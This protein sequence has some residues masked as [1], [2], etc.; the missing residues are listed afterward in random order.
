MDR[1]NRIRGAG[2]WPT[3][4]RGCGAGTSL[5]SPVG[6]RSACSTNG[7]TRVG[8]A[9]RRPDAIPDCR[10]MQSRVTG[11]ANSSS[12]PSGEW[13]TREE[14]VAGCRS[15]SAATSGRSVVSS[16]RV[17]RCWQCQD[18][19]R[20]LAHTPPGQARSPI[21]AAARLQTRNSSPGVIFENI[22]L[23]PS[24]PRITPNSRAPQF[25][26]LTKR[27]NTLDMCFSARSTD[28]RFPRHPAP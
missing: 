15:R 26:K 16:L 9:I 27:G 14:I 1:R 21:F 4:P 13:T 20:A 6:R 18:T 28:S 7:S 22:F 5:P 3:E 10:D 11:L 24:G 19:A 23:P 17:L 25:D 8:R 12:S 2:V